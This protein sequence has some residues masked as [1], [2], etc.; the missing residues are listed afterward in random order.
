MTDLRNHLKRK[1]CGHVSNIENITKTTATWQ[2]NE[3]EKLQLESSKY[4]IKLLKEISFFL[5]V[6]LKTMNCIL[7]KM[8]NNIDR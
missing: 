7:R 3:I 2:H 5:H 4:I 1:M 8:H 6:I